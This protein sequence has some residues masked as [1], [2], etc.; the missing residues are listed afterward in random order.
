MELGEAGREAVLGKAVELHGGDKVAKW[1]DG[2][3]MTMLHGACNR[4]E[5]S[6]ASAKQLLELDAD[7]N[8][9]DSHAQTPLHYCAVGGTAAHREIARH[10]IDHGADRLLEDEFDETPLD[11]AQLLSGLERTEMERLLEEYNYVA[12]T[13]AHAQEPGQVRPPRPRL[14]GHACAAAGRCGRGGA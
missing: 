7:P 3:G 5:H 14:R 6:L 12:S 10:L 1:D 2:T 11:L 8:S 4:S 13:P 9:K